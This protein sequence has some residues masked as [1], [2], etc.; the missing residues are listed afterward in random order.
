MPS[1][2][3]LSPALC[4]N[5]EMRNARS[6][7]SRRCLVTVTAPHADSP[8]DSSSHSSFHS[9]VQRVVVA[10]ELFRSPPTVPSPSQ[11]SS[12]AWLMSLSMRGEALGVAAFVVSAFVVSAFVSLSWVVPSS[13]T[14]LRA[15]C[16]SRR[17]LR[18][19]NHY[20][21]EVAFRSHKHH[22]P[23]R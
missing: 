15:A 3:R 17:G 1:H 12:A 5:D 13:W 22:S 14:C 6:S 23:Q 16:Q 4:D 7:L 8:F 11:T 9:L 20:G 19:G 2:A 18:S 21:L 10:E